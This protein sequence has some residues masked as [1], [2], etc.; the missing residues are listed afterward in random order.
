MTLSEF[1]AWFEGFTEGI[2]GAPSAKQFE[3]AM[4]KDKDEVEFTHMRLFE[5]IHTRLVAAELI[6]YPTIHFQLP[7]LPPT[8][9]Y[10]WGTPLPPTA[11]KNIHADGQPPIYR[12]RKQFGVR[13]PLRQSRGKGED[14]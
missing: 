14:C 3:K 4:L 13:V 7:L 12:T 10:V 11:T 6:V 8:Q 2:V 1:K 5:A 9:Q